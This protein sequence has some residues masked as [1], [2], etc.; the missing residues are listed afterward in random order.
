MKKAVLAVLGIVLV[1]LVVLDLENPMLLMF[2]LWIFTYI[3]KEPFGNIMSKIPG[4]IGFVVA[5]V[6]FGMVIEVFAIINNLYLSASERIL[7]DADPINDL[8]FGIL[9]Y[10]FVIVSWYLILRKIRYSQLEIFLITGIYGIFVEETGQVFLRM[11]EQPVMGTL[12]A[13]IVMFVYGLFP[14]L[15]LM[16]TED[17]FS[18]ERKESSFWAYVL[19]VAVLFFQFAVYGNTIY[20][21]LKTILS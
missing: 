5:G 15:A 2:P 9:Y 7:L 16:V 14:M 8:V 20:P 11:F 1:V 19:A 4:N 13:I 6:F 12:Y 21:A 17:T 18:L 10:T 3:F